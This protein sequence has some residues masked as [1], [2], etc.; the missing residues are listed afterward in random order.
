MPGVLGRC[1]IMVAAVAS[2][3]TGCQTAQPTL[4]DGG[5]V[6][7]GGAG[8]ATSSGASSQLEKCTESLGTL[9]VDEDVRASW[10]SQLQQYNLGPTTPVLRL[11]IQ[12]S[13]CF[14]VVERGA[15]FNNMMREREISRS[16]ESR[17]GSN[18]GQGQMVAADY[19]MSPS[20]TFSAR[21]TQGARI[22]GGGGIIGLAVGAAVAG[23]S[24]NEASTT[25][26]MVDN[27]SSVQVVAAAGSA[28]NFDFGGFAGGFGG[29]FGG[30]GGGAI[31]GYTN[32][33]EGKVIV[34]SFMDSY[35]QMVRAVRNYQAQNVR[36]GLGTG[37][38]LG[39]QGGSTPASQ[40]LNPSPTAPATNPPPAAPARNRRR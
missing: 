34:A 40:E 19:T 6:A 36:G 9:A 26:L 11:I 14:V 18:M 33:P 20:I 37:G 39:V 28:K 17:Q 23:F 29:G 21:G 2:L 10:F 15:A 13:N 31:G 35:N 38:R 5:T 1:L 12:Q 4:G 8:G 25:L 16:G 27:R 3:L 24:A 7:T 22:G 30:A 32:T